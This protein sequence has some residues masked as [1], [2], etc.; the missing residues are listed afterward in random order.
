[1]HKHE[2]VGEWVSV[3]SAQCVLQAPYVVSNS[4]LSEFGVL[5]FE[6]GYS[7]T[8]PNALTIWEA[9][10]GD[11]ANGAQ[12][13]IDQFISGGQSKWVRFECF[14]ICS[15]APGCLLLSPLLSTHR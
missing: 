5:A 6:H 11:F 14:L 9:Q 2:S 7:I 12:T 1:M 8:S 10:F 4:S 15:P 3:H 13:V